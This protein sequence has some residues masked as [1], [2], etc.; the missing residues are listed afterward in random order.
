M[1]SDNG[2]IAGRL[3]EF[4]ALL[5]LAGARYYSARA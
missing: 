5:E 3:D 2:F 1:T 4:A